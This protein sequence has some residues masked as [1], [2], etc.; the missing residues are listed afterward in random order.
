[1]PSQEDYLDNLLKDLTSDLGGVEEIA[2]ESEIAAPETAE[3]EIAAPETVESVMDVEDISDLF[4]NDIEKMLAENKKAAED[5]NAHIST[6]EQ[7][8]IEDLMNILQ[9]T[10]DE[11]LSDIHDMLQKSDRNEAVDDGIMALLQD[12]GDEE[13]FDPF[14]EEN[15]EE[16]AI[17]TTDEAAA[18][19]KA[20][21]AEKAEQRRQEKE[22]KKAEKAAR[23]AAA[24]AE[25][26]AKKAAKLEAKKAAKA[27]KE[28]VNTEEAVAEEA[29]TEAAVTEAAEE[30]FTDSLPEH[31]VAG[32]DDL[33]SFADAVEPDLFSGEEP[34]KPKKGFFAKLLDFFTEEEEE[35]SEDEIR[36]SDENKTILEEMDK[37]KKKKK[38]SK[39]GKKVAGEAQEASEDGVEN[40]S[41]KGKQPKKEKKPKKEKAPKLTEAE[42]EQTRGS[43]LSL[44]RILPVA[45]ICISIGAVIILAAYISGDYSSKRI[46]HKAYYSG[47]FQTC[48]QN[49]YGKDLNES[50]QV[51]YGKSESILRIR[52]WLREY[53]LLAEEGQEAKALDSLIQSVYAYPSLYDYSAKW[54][55]DTE[56][57]Q[58]YEQMVQILSDKY[59]LT[60]EQALE[61][62]AEEK[63]VEYSRMIYAIVNGEKFGSWNEPLVVPEE[64]PEVPEDVLPEEEELG[65]TS[66]VDNI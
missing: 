47:D 54:N 40:S 11:E 29:V 13:V 45:M 2:L 41:K 58:I 30:T 10:N 60:Q 15:K 16:K 39:K 31:E 35:A 53:E 27:A 57:A 24:K 25:K 22:A 12:D 42:P 65:D 26:E 55:A 37:D 64:K 48:Y 18:R 44:K 61:I 51:M 46:A 3:S 43:K 19:K 4:E 66:F 59:H 36:L 56:V 32:L 49:L 28:A 38:K 14:A 17:E 9:A 34:E 20:E 6:D 21:K 52:L 1:M 62:A 33:L 23:I 8:D 5:D 63:D 50:E 7:Q